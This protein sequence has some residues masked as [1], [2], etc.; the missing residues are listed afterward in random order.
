LPFDDPNVGEILKKTYKAEPP[1]S[2]EHWNNISED[3]N[4]E[5]R[6]DS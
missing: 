3:S 4:E 6:K 1:M 2:D 5:N